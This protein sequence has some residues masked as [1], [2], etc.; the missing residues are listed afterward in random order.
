MH[1]LSAALARARI[2]VCGDLMLDRYWH[3]STSRI[4]P[5]AP[6]PVVRIEQTEDRP[7]GAANVAL[8]AAVLGARVRL[9]GVVGDDEAG[10]A[11]EVMLSGTGVDCAFQREAGFATITKL[12]VMSQHQQ[13]L[14]C[15]FEAS[16]ADSPALSAARLPHP[17]PVVV[18]S[19]YAKGALRS[20]PLI[21]EA[22]RAQR[23]RVVVDPKGTDFARYAGAHVITPNQREFE[24]EVGMAVDDA[25]LVE[26]AV[27]LCRRHRLD[28]VLVTRGE[29]GMALIERHGAALHLRAE[30]R[31]V[32]DV[33]GAGDTVCAV[34]ATA[35]AA[36]FGLHEAT[37]MANAAAGVVVGKLGTS[38]LTVAE[39]QQALHGHTCGS[40][41]VDR[42][43]LLREVAEARA[44]GERIVMTNGC[45]D[46]LHAGHVSYLE[47]AR[48]LGERLIVA[49]NDDASVARLK[50]EARPV[51]PLPARM[52]VLAGL[53]S[54]DWV[55]PFGE[56]TPADLIAA[57]QPDVLV[58]GGDYRP[59]QIA[60]HDAVVAAGGEVRVLGFVP[61]YSTTALIER[62]RGPEEGT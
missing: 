6:V 37:R 33:T 16:P 28:A 15:D 54:V 47:E 35:L 57:V 13:L 8:N 32:F 62:I 52:A 44:R 48:R 27:A 4:S 2:L 45:F 38:T 1:D 24:A 39:L 19:D 58:K 21:I 30:A 11:L 14:R 43:R 60:G 25:N 56:D 18:L 59:E 22:A 31:D 34:L 3:G 55:V 10:R 46:V 12:R 20:A 50:G 61:G 5:E 9:C 49:V 40:G 7:G 42:Q 17:E 53:A 36:G 26:L 23:A 41:V 51:N 29:K